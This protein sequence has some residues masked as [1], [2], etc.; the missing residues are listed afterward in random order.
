[1]PIRGNMGFPVV[2]KE[3][4]R[5]SGQRGGAARQDVLV[6]SEF[7][8][9]SEESGDFA[10][11]VKRRKAKRRGE[12]RGGRLATRKKNRIGLRGAIEP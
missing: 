6:A 10:A 11:W 5:L 8:A 2:A 1:M 4:R 12:I 7:A 9:S 3:M